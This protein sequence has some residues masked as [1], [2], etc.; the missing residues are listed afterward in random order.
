MITE[1]D[2]YRY[3]PPS[4]QVFMAKRRKLNKSRFIKITWA[5]G[6]VIYVNNYELAGRYLYLTAS[7]VMDKLSRSHGCFYTRDFQSPAE[8]VRVE[9]CIKLQTGGFSC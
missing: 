6:Q 7:T 2:Y 8:R 5:D 1:N 3:G 4:C 9:Y